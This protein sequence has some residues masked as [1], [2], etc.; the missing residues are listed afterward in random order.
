[1][2][3]K[4]SVEHLSQKAKGQQITS[5]CQPRHA[6]NSSTHVLQCDKACHNDACGWD[7]DDCCEVIEESEVCAEGCPEIW[8]GD[9]DRMNVSHIS[10]YEHKMT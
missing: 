9:G 5:Q 8:K 4:Y 6:G 10:F 2:F 3:S 1:M 7:G